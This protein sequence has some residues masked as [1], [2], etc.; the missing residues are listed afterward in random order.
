LVAI[1]APSV[2]SLT[3]ALGAK[4]NKHLVADALGKIG[5][6]RAVPKLIN[7]LNRQLFFESII[8]EGSL[9]DIF[10]GVGSGLYAHQAIEN[11]Q[12]FFNSKSIESIITALEKITNQKFGKEVNKWSEWAKKNINKDEC[13]DYESLDLPNPME[14][15]LIMLTAI[16]SCKK[17]GLL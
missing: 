6:I 12:K 2:E 9:H 14:E 13:K 1:G 10:K 8:K 4:N 16:Q 5:D 7:E 11:I 17:L 3:K 15:T